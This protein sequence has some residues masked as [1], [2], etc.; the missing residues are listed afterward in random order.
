[1]TQ[2]GGPRS[3]PPGWQ[4]EHARRYLATN[5]QDGHIWEG[6]P[7]LLLTT[8]GRRTGKAYTT[9]LIYGED[10]GRYIVVGSRGGAPEHPQWYRNLVAQPEVGVQVLAD[11][12]R[13]RA[14]TANPE[15]K[16]ALWKLMAGIWPSYDEY[17]QRTSREIPVII[18]ERI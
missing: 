1:M 10:D 2:P 8:T 3:R 11:R 15:E 12:F 4:A 9:P 13:A 18:L 16:P 6:V 17:Q 14:R 5:G 7:T